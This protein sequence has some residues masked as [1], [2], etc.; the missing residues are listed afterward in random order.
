MEKLCLC[1]LDLGGVWPVEAAKWTP[2][3]DNSDVVLS[4]FSA[5]SSIIHAFDL[6][7]AV[8]DQRC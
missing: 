4:D 7:K 6:L 5:D 1:H 3:K 8:I 2:R